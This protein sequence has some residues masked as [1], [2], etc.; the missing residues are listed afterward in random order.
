MTFYCLLSAN[1]ANVDFLMLENAMDSGALVAAEERR[2]VSLGND[3]RLE[4]EKFMGAGLEFGNRLFSLAFSAQEREWFN[5]PGQD[6]ESF[7]TERIA[8]SVIISEV[9]GAHYIIHLRTER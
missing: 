8:L 6:E 4:S 5:S 9:V 2:S 1:Q 7:G 3:V